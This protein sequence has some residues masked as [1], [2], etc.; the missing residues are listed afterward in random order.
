MVF[1]RCKWKK[2]LE[3]WAYHGRE[4]NRDMGCTP[5]P[6][7]DTPSKPPPPPPALSP[8]PPPPWLYTPP[9]PPTLQTG[10]S[11]VKSAGVNTL[12]GDAPFALPDESFMSPTMAVMVLGIVA[13]AGLVCVGAMVVL[14][15]QGATDHDLIDEPDDMDEVNKAVLARVPT[16]SCI[17]CLQFVVVLAVVV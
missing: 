1:L 15:R 6:P 5:F 10:A 12:G 16:T 13:V 4:E 11:A 2:V 7:P 17:G 14:L 3:H 9:P 8:P